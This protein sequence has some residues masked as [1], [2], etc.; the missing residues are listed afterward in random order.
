LA[1]GVFPP[2]CPSYKAEKGRT[3]GKAYGIKV[4]FYWEHVAEQVRN[5]MG[6]ENPKKTPQ[7]MTEKKT[8][9]ALVYLS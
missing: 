6:R 2:P 9:W 7:P 8:N 1:N 5:S 3:L 4:W